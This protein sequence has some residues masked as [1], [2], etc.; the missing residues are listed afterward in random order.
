MTSRA[1]GAIWMLALL[2]PSLAAAQER[3]FDATL[4]T[5]ATIERSE[6]NQRGSAAAVGLSASRAFS[7]R[8]RGE[9]EL[10]VPAWLEDARGEPYHRDVLVSVSAIRQ[11]R[12]SGVRPFLAA[13]LSVSWTETRSTMCIAERVPPFG[14]PPEL[15]GVSCDEPDVVATEKQTHVGAGLVLLTGAGVQIPV[16]DRVRIVAD[17]RLNLAPTSVLVRPGLGIAM[18]F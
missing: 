4:K 10:W 12:S 7:E 2:T 15:T 1:C 5:G 6:D 9:V 17:V 8:W 16:G 3:R 18:A 14:G 13:G 11:L